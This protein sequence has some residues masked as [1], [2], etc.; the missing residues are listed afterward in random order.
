MSESLCNRL[1]K[2]PKDT[3]ISKVFVKIS[4]WEK[5]SLVEFRKMEKTTHSGRLK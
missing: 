2:L 3:S 1:A 4:D 5:D